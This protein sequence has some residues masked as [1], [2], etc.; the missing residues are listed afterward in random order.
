MDE[1]AQEGLLVQ[2]L[3]VLRHRVVE[4]QLFVFESE[5]QSSLSSISC[6]IRSISAMTAAASTRRL[7]YRCRVFSSSSRNDL[8]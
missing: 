5:P 6:F 8:A 4:R 3:G 7:W 2:M 1:V